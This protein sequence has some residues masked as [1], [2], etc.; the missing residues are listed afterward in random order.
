MIDSD[1]F[2][3]NVGIIICNDQR[4]LFW[5]RRVGQN[6]WQFPQGGIRSSEVPIE[7]MYR[8]L[9]EEV[10]LMPCQVEV[11]GYTRRWLRYRLPK[12]FIRRHCGPICIG[13]KQIWFM[14]R[15]NC[16]EQAFCL[17]HSE[18]PEFDAWRWVKYWQPVREVVYFKR[19]VYQ[20]ALEELAPLVYPEGLPERADRS[21]GQVS[22]FRHGHR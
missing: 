10:G 18:K 19:H 3:P 22:L 17:D 4:R 21:S 6:A 16:G 20:K 2:R 5:G 8:E 11:L 12:R 13:Q 7:A 14:L 1:G 9:E 15:V